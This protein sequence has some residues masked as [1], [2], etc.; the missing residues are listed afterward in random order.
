MSTALPVSQRVG[1]RACN[2]VITDTS[3]KRSYSIGTGAY[4]QQKSATDP[5]GPFSLTLNNVVVGSAIQVEDQAGT[6]TFY[7][8][9]AASTTVVVVLSAYPVGNSLN[10]LRIKIRKGSASP[11][12][13]PYETLATSV[14]GS[15]SIY[16]SQIP[17]E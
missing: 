2:V 12:Y 15:Q 9:V 13:Q 5:V 16:V 1:C 14:V 3:I 6:T 11:F 7:N 4:S 8:G 10:N 17:D